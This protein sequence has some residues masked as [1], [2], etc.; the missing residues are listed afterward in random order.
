MNQVVDGLNE[1]VGPYRFT[2]AVERP[3][4]LRWTAL[5]ARPVQIS[6]YGRGAGRAQPSLRGVRSSSELGRQAGD[7]P[8]GKR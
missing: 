4:S 3:N 7:R 2:S 1:I 8:R 5:R 6:P